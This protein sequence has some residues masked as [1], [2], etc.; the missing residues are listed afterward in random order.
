MRTQMVMKMIMLVV[1]V[2]VVVV[3]IEN[4]QRNHLK[5]Y[6]KTKTKIW[7]LSLFGF[8]DA[9]VFVFLFVF[10]LFLMLETCS[11]QKC[12]LNWK[13]LYNCWLNGS[14]S[15]QNR[16][17][18]YIPNWDFVILFSFLFIYDNASKHWKIELAKRNIIWDT[19]R[20]RLSWRQW[21]RNIKSWSLIL[22]MNTILELK[23]LWN[24]EDNLV[25]WH[26]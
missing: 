11:R 6:I 22:E 15:E 2:V 26:W 21:R 12:S 17:N 1:V 3:E 18:P 5:R 8:V 14:S 13:K 23:G 20:H 4:K 7:I 25:Y 9:L 10:H 16:W 19:Y 24:I